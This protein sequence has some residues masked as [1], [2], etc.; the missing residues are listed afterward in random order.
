MRDGVV[1]DFATPLDSASLETG[2]VFVRLWNYQRSA[3][4][5]SGRFALDGEP[6]TTPWGVAQVVASKDGRSAFVHLPD[7]PRAM[8]VEVRHD[9]RF[10]DGTPARGAAYLTV[11]EAV[12]T[13]F[14]GFPEIDFSKEATAVVEAK[15]PPPSID[16]GRALAESLGCLACHSTDGTTEGK[17][18]PTWRNLYLANRT[19]ADGT[20]D[21]ADDVYLRE[22]ILE[23][24]KRRV[25]VAPVEMPSYRGVLSEPQLESIILFIKSLRGR[26]RPGD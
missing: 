9:F 16:A 21:V 26:P 15:E 13:D 1:L 19:F 23:P 7:L 22:K 4:Y 17:V 2:N 25:S 3:A 14:A 12:R 6:G 18:G 11:H 8:Q 24:M 5:G 20:T 10:A